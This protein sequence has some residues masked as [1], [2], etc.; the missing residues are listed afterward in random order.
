MFLTVLSHKFHLFTLQ[1]GR[2]NDAKAVIQNLWGE[3][4]VERAIE[5]FQLVI[6]NDGSDLDSRWSELLEEP[7]SRGCIKVVHRCF[8]LHI[9]FKTP[10][11]VA[12]SSVLEFI[13]TR[14]EKLAL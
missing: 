7:H 14:I 10:F 11:V 6:K 3:S 4:E 5:D 13:T 2:L 12:I 1:V 8:G 9:A